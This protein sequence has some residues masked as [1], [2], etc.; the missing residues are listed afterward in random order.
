MNK[1]YENR[2]A[3]VA[4]N[5]KSQGLDALI[6]SDPVSIYYLSG[7]DNQPYERM[8]LL[9]LQLDGEEAAGVK[10]T[11]FVNK[12]FNVAEN[13][14]DNVWYSDT[15]DA[16]G[17]V[18]ERCISS[19]TAG[20][21]KDWPARFLLPL[22][23]RKPQVRFLLGSDCVDDERG[24]KD[25]TEI[26][27]M[28]EAS[29]INDICIEKG[30][31]YVK[32]GMTEK[33]VAA[34]IERCFVEE[35]AAGP[36]FE[37]IVSFGANAADPHHT[38]DDTTV[39]EGDCVLIDMGCIKDR[40][41]SDMTRTAF[42]KSASAEYQKI[43]DIVREANE[44]A[45]KLIKPGVP[46]SELDKAARDHITAAGYGEY[47]THRLGHFIGMGEHEKGDVSSASTLIAKPGMIFS[48][49]PGIYLSGRMGVR[50]EDLVLVTETGCEILNHVD[51]HWK[52]IG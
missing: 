9:Y 13:D 38:P 19:G 42:F 30:L 34:Y 28:K 25:E 32:A 24:C 6:V 4:A 14:F 41:C 31:A 46:L 33:E 10:G 16:V 20:V 12:L 40:Y 11:L 5:M 36:S 2:L 22:M 23:E 52:V 21:D 17:F 18:A 3:R 39:Q 7:V 47:F 8:Y 48:I 26:A 49:E 27:L 44:A 45:E 29:R 50:V 37:T 43:H 15:D 1:L 35:G 51:K